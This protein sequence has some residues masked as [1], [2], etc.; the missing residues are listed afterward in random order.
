MLG[1][2]SAV[3]YYSVKGGIARKSDSNA[4][5]AWLDKYCEENP[6]KQVSD[7][8][9]ALVEELV[10]KQFTHKPQTNTNEDR[11]ALWSG[12]SGDQI[13]K[14]EAMREILSKFKKDNNLE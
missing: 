10:E 9:Y 6:L 1:F 11:E 13:K 5:A 8:T 12:L 14:I 7:G 3:G 4:Y 2:I